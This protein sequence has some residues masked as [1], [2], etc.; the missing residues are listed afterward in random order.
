[1]IDEDIVVSDSDVDSDYSNIEEEEP[2]RPPKKKTK[3]QTTTYNWTEDDLPMDLLLPPEIPQVENIK[4]PLEDFIKFF[5]FDLMQEIVDQTNLYCT[6]VT[7]NWTTNKV[8][9]LK[10]I[11]LTR[12]RTNF[13]KMPLRV[14]YVIF[15]RDSFKHLTD[16]R[17]KHIDNLTKI[18]Y[19]LFNA[20]CDL[21]N[22]TQVKIFRLDWGFKSKQPNNTFT[23]GLFGDIIY[24]RADISGTV[25]FTPANRLQHFNY[26]FAPMREFSVNFIFRAPPLAYYSNLFTLPFDKWVW[27]TIAGFAIFCGYVVRIIFSWES[28]EEVFEEHNENRPSFLDIVMMQIAFICQMDFHHEPRSVSGKLV[29]FTILISM[30]FIYT[31]FSAR[32]VLLLQSNT[33]SIKTLETLYNAKLDLG[34]E[35]KSYNKYYFTGPNDRSNEYWR[36]TIYE[37]KIKTSKGDNF[38]KPEDGMQLVRDSYFAF[39]IERTVSNYLIKKS[40]TNDQT[41]S[42]RVVDSIYKS[43]MPHLFCHKESPYVDF[44]LVSFRR[45]SETG[46]H[47][48]E[49]KNCFVKQPKCLGRGN[50][51]VS[52]GL[53][54]CYFAFAV[55]GSGIC[56]SIAILTIEIIA[57]RHK[58]I[59]RVI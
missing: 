25:S 10:E 48:R 51:F 32:I 17:Y 47:N 5:S 16:Y 15:D 1:M 52:V 12:N 11:I 54:E 59:K 2:I 50:I 20:L 44:F 39:H 22:T 21:L 28:R 42:L 55:F 41:C 40:F 35:S 57:A 49:Y 37:K 7:G 8:F 13:L 9:S 43:D 38:L 29:I 26:L 58:Y 45:L 4:L 31:A 18:N 23:K 3:K 27:L 34:V 33:N 30:T 53:K 24:D 19:I 14:A 56:L 36:K 6:Q 46:I